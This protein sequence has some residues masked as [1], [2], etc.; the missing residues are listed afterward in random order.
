MY[1]IA[2]VMG[3]RFHFVVSRHLFEWGNGI[4][5]KI[6]QNLGVFSL[7][8]GTTDLESI[9]TARKILAKPQGKLA[10]FLEGEPPSRINDFLLPFQQGVIQLAFWSYEDVI[11]NEPEEDI[12]VLPVFIKY[13]L[14]GTEAHIKGEIHQSLLRIERK[15]GIDPKNNNFLQRTL[16]IGK[17]LLENAE[18]EYGLEQETEKEW[19]FRIEKLRHKILD[20]IATKFRIQGYNFSATALEKLRYLLGILEMK[21]IHYPDPRLPEMH[22]RDFQ[23]T[24]RELIKAHAIINIYPEYLISYPSPE[25]IGEWIQNFEEFLFGS[26]N[27]RLRKAVVRIKPALSIK[28]F[29][30]AYKQ[31][32]KI[33]TRNILDHIKKELLALLDEC[34]NLS[35]PVV[36][37][38]D[39]RDT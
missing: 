38:Y 18:K 12:F 19:D 13:L 2:N 6:I 22:Y 32:K 35:K 24:Q 33:T 37:P 8:T 20:N 31:S 36:R 10:L 28:S 1:H 15:L 23:W 27:F 16:T 30:E 9:K 5:G 3:T 4:V 26:S 34:K 29:Y 11:K 17:T 14:K 21:T 25:R 7:L 39:L